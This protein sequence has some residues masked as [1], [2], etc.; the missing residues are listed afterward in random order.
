[1]EKNWDVIIVG[2][3][4]AG[5]VAALYTSRA[6]LKT[7]VIG[8]PM[9][10]NI[11]RAPMVMNYPAF[12]EGI[13]GKDL[14]K[15]Y[16]K[17]AKRYKTQTI[18]GEVVGIKK[19]KGFEVRTEKK[20]V[21]FSKAVIIACGKSYTSCCIKGEDKF[22]GKGVHY[23]ATCDGYAYKGKKIAVIGNGNHAADEA[24]ELLS[25]TKD[26]T[27]LLHG[28]KNEMSSHMQKDIAKNKI[29]VSGE[30]IKEFKGGKFLEKIVFE[31]GE[32]AFSGAF[33]AMGKASATS[34]A[35]ELAIETDN[36]S[37]KI[38]RGGRT[39]VKGIYA[40]GDCTGGNPQTVKSAGEGCNA[41]LSVV[42]D[43]KGMVYIDYGEK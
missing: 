18:V 4:P 1:M 37:I 29:K 36:D 16:L 14:I 2:A 10:S 20:E 6:E 22:T 19:G 12:P 39:G 41:A 8:D 23:C 40:A 25:Y 9:K 35:K 43:L 21:F 26:V 5:L 28:M 33:I 7:L 13:T 31:K 27:I 42:K 34:F 30:K 24:L 3:G 32:D 11:A 17:Q 15:K 38:D